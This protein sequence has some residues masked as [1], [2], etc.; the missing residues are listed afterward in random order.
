MKGWNYQFNWVH[1]G[2]LQV[3]ILRSP[4]CSGCFFQHGMH[5]TV[6]FFCSSALLHTE[7]W[8]IKQVNVHI[9]AY[10]QVFLAA[11][12][13]VK[14][15]SCCRHPRVLRWRNLGSPPS[16]N[17]IAEGGSPP[18]M[19]LVLRQK[20]KKQEEY[21]NSA[22]FLLVWHFLA[23]KATF[24]P[25]ISNPSLILFGPFCAKKH[26][27]CVGGHLSAMGIIQGNP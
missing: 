27:F 25:L 23:Q 19:H 5:L 12:H 14:T 11:N 17:L 8:F 20:S 13:W 6:G 1:K 15:L 21:R 16:G 3:H 10:L 2:A 7:F 4:F 18:F 26:H 9:N 24:S 22:I